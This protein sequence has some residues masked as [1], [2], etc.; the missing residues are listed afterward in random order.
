[1]SLNDLI[2]R[3]LI[4]LNIHSNYVEWNMSLN[5]LM[6]DYSYLEINMW[7][8]NNKNTKIDIYFIVIFIDVIIFVIT[9]L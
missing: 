9:Y 4:D 1:M 6:F 5:D 7:Y 3:F 2:L 8:M